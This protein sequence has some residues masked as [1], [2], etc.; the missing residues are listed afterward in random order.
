MT[1]KARKTGKR[2]LA[3]FMTVLMLMS[4][5]VFAPTASAATAG[6][7]TW[8]VNVVSSNNTGGWDKYDWKVYGK[9]NNGTGSETQ[10]KSFSRKIDFNG[11]V[12]VSGDQTT[13]QF[14]TKVTFEYSFGGGITHRKMDAT[15][16]LDLYYNGA[17]QPAIA[18]ATAYSYEWG[19]NKGTVT[20]TVGSGAYPKATTTSISGGS[21]SVNVPTDGSSTNYTSAFSAGTVYDQYGVSWYQD[22]TLSVSSHTGVT[23]SSGKVAV[24]SNGNASNNYT[25]TVTASCGSASATSNVTVNV[26]DY[27]VEFKDWNGTQL[28]RQTGID[29]GASATPPS[30]PSRQPDADNHYAF[31]SWNGTYQNLKTGAQTKTVTATYTA[32][33]HTPGNW[34][35]DASQHWKACTVC[36]YITSAKANHTYGAWSA[37]TASC[38]EGG[39]QSRTCTACGYTQTQNTSAL[40]HNWVTTAN[41]DHLVSAATCTAAAVYHK[42]CSRCGANHPTDTFTS[43]NPL[44]HDF[45]G[46]YQNVSDGRHNRK[47]VRCSE[48]GIG[49]T[50]NDTEA[51]SGGTANCVDKAVCQHCNTAYGVVDP[52]NHKSPENRA[53]V[54]NSCETGGYTAGV[55]CTACNQWVSGH[56]PV[57]A[58]GHDYTGAVHSLG[59]GTHN[60]ACKNNCGTYGKVENG[61]QVKDGTVSCDATYGNWSDDT[62][63]CLEGGSHSRTCSECGYTQ[64]EATSQLGHNWVETTEVTFNVNH[65]KTAATCEEAAVYYKSC[66]RCGVNSSETFTVGNPLGHDY[67][68][69]PRDN[70]DGTH[71]WLCQNGCGTYGKVDNGTQVKGGKTPPK[72]SSYEEKADEPAVATEAA[73]PQEDAKPRYGWRCMICGYVVEMDELPDDFTCP[74]CGMGRDMFER[75]EL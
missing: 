18:S 73:A 33:A 67:T 51:C 3:L 59:N 4:A 55:Y 66:S 22:A 53:A 64:T 70:G 45:T 69:A 41:A 31:S 35:T 6:S 63:T 14:P 16:Y 12:N 23:L 24:N 7:Y 17:W 13:S 58:K 71:S 48:Y 75:I 43:G 68:G 34:L 74:M 49:T 37:D 56:E 62:A 38:T 60:W 8:R 61:T 27:I 19:T 25:V 11:T 40:G 44:G 50:L 32:T 20:V 52:A 2:S 5:W 28:K 15:I 21:S 72:A 65:L 1:K 26:F 46:A 54:A 42:Y 47:C 9:G 57:A 39:S 10:I 30:N 29:Y 36:G